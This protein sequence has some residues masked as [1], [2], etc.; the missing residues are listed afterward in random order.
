MKETH[1][2]QRILAE[3]LREAADSY[4]IQTLLREFPTMQS[5]MNATEP[6]MM[7]IRGIG[8][9]KAKRLSAILNFVRYAQEKPHGGRIII[10][11]AQDIYDLVRS[12]LEYLTVEQFMVIGLNTKNHVMVQ[13]T[14]SVGTLNASLVH[15]RETFN[16]LIRRACASVIL[17]HNHPSGD[18][19][20]SAEDIQL[21]KRLVEVSR[22]IDIPVLDHVIIGQGRY[23]SL[24]GRGDIN[25]R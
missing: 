21:T 23:V 16:L 15:P 19:E 7:E 12:E 6:D 24:K 20:P 9:A 3:C 14:I 2:L 4:T 8:K 5:L 1:A 11:S 13:H 18:P 10:R 25:S 17:V 22:I